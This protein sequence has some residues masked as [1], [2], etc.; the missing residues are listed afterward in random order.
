MGCRSS[1]FVLTL[2]AL[3]FL[4]PVAAQAQF[5][6]EFTDGN[7]ITV[8]NY[9]DEGQKI[10][11][12]T[13][14]GWFAF[15]KEDVA[16]IIDLTTGKKVRRSD[17]PPDSRSAS[18]SETKEPVK[19]PPVDSEPAPERNKT[20]TAIETRPTLELLKEAVHS[21]GTLSWQDLFERVKG[22]AFQLRY[23]VALLLGVKALKL[24]FSAGI[25]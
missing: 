12:H 16:N 22:G 21:L 24:F 11:I 3:L 1:R 19:S 2:S 15:R 10:K 8:S 5:I 20:L 4:L 18:P 13:L 6:I 9:K 17:T 25:R 14:E 7:R 23:V